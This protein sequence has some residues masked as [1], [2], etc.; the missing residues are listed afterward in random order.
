MQSYIVRLTFTINV[1]CIPPPLV[2]QY[3][4]LSGKQMW[5][6]TMNLTG[7]GSLSLSFVYVYPICSQSLTSIYMHR[8][9]RV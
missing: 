2:S 4:P 5:I 9:V 6:D 3:Y 7:I 1:L 8:R